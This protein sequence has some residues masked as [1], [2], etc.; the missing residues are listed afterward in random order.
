MS[1]RANISR[2][3]SAKRTLLGTVDGSNYNK[4]LSDCEEAAGSAL[5]VNGY[6]KMSSRIAAAKTVVPGVSLQSA[7]SYIERE[8][9]AIQNEDD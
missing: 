3:T 9:A 2:L 1:N 5:V 6:S 4:H 7:A 8:I